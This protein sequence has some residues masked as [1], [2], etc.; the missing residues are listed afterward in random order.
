[1]A[2]VLY[3]LFSLVLLS[4]S[5]DDKSNSSLEVKE[6]PTPKVNVV[7]PVKGN[8]QQSFRLSASLMGGNEAWIISQTEGVIIKVL[9]NLGQ[10]V[11]ADQVLTGITD[12]VAKLNYQQAQVSFENAKLEYST[13]QDLYSQGASSSSLLKSALSKLSGAEAQLVNAREILNNTHIKAPFT[14]TIAEWPQ[15]ISVGNYL[16]R[17]QKVARIVDLDHLKAE[18][19]LGE[20]AIKSLSLDSKVQ[21]RLQGQNSWTA[22]VIKAIAAG[23]NGNTGSYA[24]IINWDNT[25]GDVVR[26]G[27]TI[28]VEIFPDGQQD[29]I[30]PISALYQRGSSQGIYLLVD[31]HPVYKAIESPRFFGDNL[32]VSGI[33]SFEDLVIVTPADSLEG[34]ASFDYQLVQ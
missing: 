4:C 9:V 26:S 34:E 31:S 8:L 11:E 29:L 3:L 7:H 17:G 22:A 6:L 27:M 25:W 16:K 10:H 30:V 2:K 13:T 33:A 5:Q 21:V 24:I 18:V 23:A 12:T 28:D 14:G 15:E 19:Y 20:E 32:S 1:M